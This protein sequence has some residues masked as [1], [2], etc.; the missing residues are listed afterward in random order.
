MSQGEIERLLSEQRR[1]SADL[2]AVAAA[3]RTKARGVALALHNSERVEHWLEAEAARLAR[4]A[5]TRAEQEGA[6]G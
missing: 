5:Q 2:R 4:V 6:R 1:L 3:S